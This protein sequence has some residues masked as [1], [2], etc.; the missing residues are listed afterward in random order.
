MWD[1]L[2]PKQ[3]HRCQVFGKIPGSRQA[4]FG[5]FLPPGSRRR[6]LTAVSAP[7]VAVLEPP[8]PPGPKKAGI[9]VVTSVHGPESRKWM[10]FLEFSR[11]RPGPKWLG[12]LFSPTSHFCR[13]SQLG[14]GRAGRAGK[15]ENLTRN[16]FLAISGRAGA[17]KIPGISFI[18][19]IRARVPK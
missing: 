13:P 12:N 1:V 11:P 15:S 9:G 10:E 4:P 3:N 5:S 2:C 8:P 6:L 17:G 14:R 18:C 7:I 16:Q 19:A